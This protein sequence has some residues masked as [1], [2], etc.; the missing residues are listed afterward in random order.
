MNN[1]D[2]PDNQNNFPWVLLGISQ[3]FH[4]PLL[5]LSP[6]TPRATKLQPL[7]IIGYLKHNTLRFSVR[8]WCCHQQLHARLNFVNPWVLLGI[9]KYVSYFQI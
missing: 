8:C 7:G 9:A 1:Q 4:R 5:V 6:T 3:P 2:N